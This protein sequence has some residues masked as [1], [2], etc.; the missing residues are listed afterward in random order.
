MRL[1]IVS[2]IPEPGK[3]SIACKRWKR[4]EQLIDVGHFKSRAVIADKKSLLA[5]YRLPAHLDAAGVLPGGKFPGVADEIFQGDAE[6]A[7]VAR[8]SHSGSDLDINFTSRIVST[9]IL[10]QRLGQRGYIDLSPHEA[11][12]V[13]CATA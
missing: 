3:S 2:P 4:L 9:Q 12:R 8:G 5:V 7:F 1:T 10:D 13:R 11:A 6:Q